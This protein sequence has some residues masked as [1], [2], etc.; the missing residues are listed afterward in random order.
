MRDLWRQVAEVTR[1][2]PEKEVV[3]SILEGTEEAKR[4]DASDLNIR[5]PDLLLRQ[6]EREIHRVCLGFEMDFLDI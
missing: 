1:D 5:V 3:E 6:C 2:S 4:I